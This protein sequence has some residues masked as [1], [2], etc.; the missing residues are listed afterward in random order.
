MYVATDGKGGHG[1]KREAVGPTFSSFNAMPQTTT[2]TLGTEK[3]GRCREV[4]NKSQCMDFLSAGTKNKVAVSG[5]SAV[6]NIFLGALLR[7]FVHG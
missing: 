2:A 5:G 7:H 6:F 1:L 3:S 4:L